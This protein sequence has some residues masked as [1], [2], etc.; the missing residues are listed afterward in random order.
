MFDRKKM[1][2]FVL[3]IIIGCWLLTGQADEGSRIM[4][5]FLSDKEYSFRSDNYMFSGRVLKKFSDGWIVV[6][7]THDLTFS[8]RGKVMKINLAQITIIE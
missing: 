2:W 1:C 8:L 7:I 4:D 3:G 6:E 5:T